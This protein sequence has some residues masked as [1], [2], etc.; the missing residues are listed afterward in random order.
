M[1]LPEPVNANVH[2]STSNGSI[3]T[4]YEVTTSRISKNVLEG[5]IGSGGPS[6]DLET[7]NGSIRLLKR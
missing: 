2:A 1:R 4:D 6:I 3:N 5:R 7:S